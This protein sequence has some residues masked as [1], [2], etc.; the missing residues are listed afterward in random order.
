MPLPALALLV[1]WIDEAHGAG[2]KCDATAWTHDPAASTPYPVVTLLG[3]TFSCDPAT[4]EQFCQA[5]NG[6]KRER[7]CFLGVGAPDQRK[8]LEWPGVD[9]DKCQQYDMA[10][11]DDIL[12][13]CGAVCKNA[14]GCPLAEML[15]QEERFA[16]M[17]KWC[18]PGETATDVASFPLKAQISTNFQEDYRKEDGGFTKFFYP[19]GRACGARCKAAVN[20]CGLDDE[21]GVSRFLGV[22][23]GCKVKAVDVPSTA[24]YLAQGTL[25]TIIEVHSSES[26]FSVKWEGI[27]DQVGAGTDIVFPA[28]MKWDFAFLKRGYIEMHD[29]C[30]RCHHQ[31]LQQAEFPFCKFQE[32][33]AK[34]KAN[35]TDGGKTCCC[36]LKAV[37][38]EMCQGEIDEKKVDKAVRFLVKAD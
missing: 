25:G 14:D 10:K 9:I 28:K 13:D 8:Y 15:A 27:A 23:V 11:F 30:G 7:F 21:N 31:Y 36:S 1:L 18:S 6:K 4:H 20:G 37:V 29:N 3:E 24:S 26:S 32:A 22:T 35:S 16:E 2:L 12:E 34:A 19:S 5:F 38:T 17:Q 33:E